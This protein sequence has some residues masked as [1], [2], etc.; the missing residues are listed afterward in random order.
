M[1]GIE[2]SVPNACQH[3]AEQTQIDVSSNPFPVLL[4]LDD[5]SVAQAAVRVTAA[6]ADARGALPTVLRV[7]EL[8]MYC[9]PES[10]PELANAE[11]LILAAESN[12]EYRNELLD[13]VAK[14]ARHPIRWRAALEV[15]G[16]VRCI[17]RRA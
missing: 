4:A 2:V 9:T 10:L 15:G 5:D 11:E 17:V 8:D 6:L 13:R 12:H 7:I 14:L 1:P 16:D 3:T